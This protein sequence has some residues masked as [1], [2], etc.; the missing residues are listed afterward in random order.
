MHAF[1]SYILE[2]QLPELSL[3][4]Q[5]PIPKDKD[6]EL[7]IANLP[8][9]NTSETAKLLYR[10]LK[11]LNRMDIPPKT[12]LSLTELLATPLDRTVYALENTY[13]DSDF[14]LLEKARH[15]VFLCTKLAEELAIAYK[16]VI[17]Y[18]NTPKIGNAQHNVLAYAVFCA[19]HRLANEI[20]ATGL[21]YQPPP[22]STWRELHSLFVFAD[23]NK[24][25]SKA[26]KINLPPHNDQL[27]LTLRDLYLR[28]LLFA[29]S[30]AA[31]LRQREIRALYRNILRWTKSINLSTIA[32]IIP[33][34]TS[35]I[36]MLDKDAPPQHSTLIKNLSSN[37]VLELDTATLIQNLQTD[38]YSLNNDSY[39]TKS[40]KHGM[41]TKLAKQRLV[42]V[43]GKA[44]QRYF[45]RT[46]L[47]FELPLVIGLNAIYTLLQEQMAPKNNLP[48]TNQ[49][50]SD[51]WS[52]AFSDPWD[53]SSVKSNFEDNTNTRNFYPTRSSFMLTESSYLDAPSGLELSPGLTIESKTHY[54]ETSSSPIILCTINESIGGYCIEWNKKNVPKIKIGEVIGIRTS[55]QPFSCALAVVRWMYDV[56]GQGLQVGV[57]VLAP[58]IKAA[59][60]VHFKTAE[61]N[62]IPCLLIPALFESNSNPSL[63]VPSLTWSVD[64]GMNMCLKE[65]EGVMQEIRLLDLIEA[66]G[67]FAHF[68]FTRK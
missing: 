63:I 61:Q 24:W 55:I 42:Q 12:R 34:D 30:G 26:F 21:V 5:D 20:Y 31:R 2:L 36:V 18:L 62:S 39:M 3:S 13:I 27:E 51:S 47:N 4:V 15:K 58:N 49:K 60:M 1:T 65:S 40:G 29:V 7:W 67:M 8:I 25:A 14:P 16:W 44:P 37:T 59:A 32:E 53:T 17:Q 48:V 35:F 9:I 19:V 64:T 11:G 54:I 52:I 6:M 41:L 66:N 56:P 46:Q 57:Q 23:A 50:D 38:Y 43:L 10:M 28:S 45:P 22:K 33:S 68:Y